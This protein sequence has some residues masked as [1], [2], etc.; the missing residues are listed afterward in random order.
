LTPPPGNA[1]AAGQGRIRNYR[2]LALLGS[3][4]LFLSTLEYLIPRPLPFMRI[5]L[6]NLPLLLALDLFPPGAF[7]LLV[8]IKISGQALITGT[9]FSYVFLFSLAGSSVSALVMYSL[10]RLL[11]KGRISFTGLGIAGAMLSNL[12]QLVLARFF[13]FGEGVRFLAPLFLASGLITGAALGLFC[14]AFAAKSRWYRRALGGRDGTE[15][16]EADQA[17]AARAGDVKTGGS[18]PGEHGPDRPARRIRRQEQW[19]RL[20]RS[21]DLFITGLVMMAIF[22][23]TPSPAFKAL[24]FLFFWV[25]TILSGKK[26]RPFITLLMMAAIVFFNLLVP[27]GKILA[28][29]GPVKISQGA[30][31]AGL[32]RALTLE[33]LI[34]LSGAFIRP[35]LRLPGA[36]GALLGESF[37]FFALLQNRKTVFDRRRIIE[38]IDGLML[39]L[40]APEEPDGAGPAA[41]AAPARRRPAALVLL[42]LMV[43]ACLLLALAGSEA[44]WAT[45]TGPG[46]A[47]RWLPGSWG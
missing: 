8:L 47:P 13:V 32:R 19:G 23:F 18:G 7:A 29:W 28:E 5:G 30:L 21:E 10:R 45:V 14:E 38:G 3:F 17:G 24:Q 36:F 44:A 43:L 16:V 20:F 35:D 31:Q 4:C 39:E 1:G 33:G 22:L 27:Y 9:L 12:I 42:G 25:L 37:R 2:S 11:G 40:D 15:A 46:P 6:A 41:A 26:T 34:L